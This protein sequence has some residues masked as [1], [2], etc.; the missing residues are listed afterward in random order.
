MNL[1]LR[2]LGIL[3]TGR[4]RD[5]PAVGCEELKQPLQDWRLRA[6]EWRVRDSDHEIEFARPSVWTRI[7]M[8]RQ[9]SGH[10]RQRYRE[11]IERPRIRNQLPTTKDVADRCAGAASLL[12][13][14]VPKQHDLEVAVKG[15][16][17][18]FG[19]PTHNSHFA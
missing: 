7:S 19:W 14:V 8:T 17:R 10:Y 11:E 18:E 3:C 5:P 6:P 16:K 15:L 1:L 9:V 12:R 4:K 13:W 2:L